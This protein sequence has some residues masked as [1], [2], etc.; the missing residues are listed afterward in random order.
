V[1]GYYGY[2]MILTYLNVISAMTGIYFALNQNIK[3]ACFCLVIS[4]ICDMFDGMVARTK[5]NRTD[6]E[7]SYGI[8]IDSLADVVGFGILPVIIGYSLGLEQ[9]PYIAVMSVYILAVLIRLAYYNVTEIEMQQQNIKRTHYTG[10]PVT[11][12]AVIVPLVCIFF[13]IRKSPEIYAVMLVLMSIAYLIKIKVPK[14]RLDDAILKFLY[15]TSFGRAILKLLVKVFV[16]RLT[17][18]ILNSFVS[19]IFIGGF[20]KNNNIDMSE[21]KKVKYKSFND[22]FKREVEEGSRPFSSN[23]NDLS[24]PC[25]GKLTAFSITADSLFHIKKSVYDIGGLLQDNELANEFMGGTCL[26]FRLTPEDYHGYCFIDDGEILSHKKI[27]GVFHTVRPIALGHYKV[28]L[29]NAREYTVIQT[30]HFDKM[31]QIEI[32]AMF[33][34]KISNRKTEGTVLRGEKKGVFE[35][36]GSTVMT[37]FKKDAILPDEVIFT[38]TASDKETIV[39]LGTVI[40]KSLHE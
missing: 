35:F 37:L 29:Q 38:N 12:A 36:G 15:T 4:G 7:K 25:D 27:K 20:I 8:Q 24:S 14:L 1:L 11:C 18:L 13:D 26:I 19:K 23:P 5:K 2:T 34:G 17:G 33:I 30:S 31:I 28:F 32:G 6:R 16:S 9:L 40:G 21:Y 3:Y 39:K 22:F 10:M